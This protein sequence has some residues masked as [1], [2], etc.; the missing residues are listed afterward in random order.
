MHKCIFTQA[1]HSKH[2]VASKGRVAGV[3][4]RILRF[5][6][7]GSLHGSDGVARLRACAAGI[8]RACRPS[9]A[10]LRLRAR[11]LCTTCF[12]QALRSWG[13]AFLISRKVGGRAIWRGRGGGRKQKQKTGGGAGPRASRRLRVGVRKGNLGESW[14]IL[15][16]Q[17]WRTTC[18]VDHL[19]GRVDH[20]HGTYIVDHSWSLRP[21]STIYTVTYSHIIIVVAIVTIIYSLQYRLFISMFYVVPTS[22]GAPYCSRASHTR[23]ARTVRHT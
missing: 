2:R 20:M 1:F 19:H 8:A 12:V 13:G 22:G 21:P 17:S 7:R 5:L 3:A 4:R 6:S 23:S 10:R 15:G 11:C 14:G 18:M 16:K 9:Q